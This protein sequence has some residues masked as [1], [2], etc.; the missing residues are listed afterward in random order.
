M[1][2]RLL[3]FML[4]P[5]SLTAQNAVSGTFT[6]ASEFSFAF[7]YK[8][9]PNG[10]D[11]VKRARLNEEG[12]FTVELDSSQQPGMY[13]VVYAIPPEENNFDFIYNAEEDV[14]FEYDL[15]DGITFK[16]SNE[17]K[18]WS[19]YLKSMGMVNQTISNYFQT[20]GSD[21]KAFEEIFKTLKETQSAYESSAKG[22]LVEQLIKANY[23]Y[24][25]ETYEDLSTYSRKLKETYFDHIDFD[26][27][28]LQSSSFITERIN[29]YLFGVSQQSSDQ[30]YKNRID[31]IAS[32]IAG[33][34]E[35]TQLGLYQL[36][37]EEFIQ[38]NNDALTTYVGSEYLLPLAQQLDQPEL[39]KK[40][41]AQQRISIGS[42]APDFIIKDGSSLYE[43]DSA[44]QYLLI[45]WSSGCSHCLEEV[46]QVHELLKD[47]KKTQVI[48][49]ALEDGVTAWKN[50]I[51]NLPAFTHVYGEKKWDNPIV[52]DYNLTAT[53]TYFLLD[54]E[55]RII[56]KP[57]D[58]KAL[59]KIIKAQ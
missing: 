2:S 14:V 24:I 57:Y 20:N 30:D 40:V 33:S 25:P 32:A 41:E 12:S 47:R 51:A 17:N 1:I 10:A 4:I 36:L 35:T 21:P 16:E 27:K 7:I 19:S 53:P 3:I 46:P 18:L 8:A 43:L 23:P 29:G 59:E 50:T 15:N 42:K 6:P 54:G 56:E 55:K 13:K 34:K 39:V 38:I 58:Y 5:L 31:N 37:W 26:N 9:T 44:E 52:E 11:F 22:M 49:Y 48:A 45:F 28:F